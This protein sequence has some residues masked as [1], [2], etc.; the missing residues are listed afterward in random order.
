MGCRLGL[1]TAGR[2][3]AVV[4]TELSPGLWVSSD[5]CSK[6]QEGEM[7]VSGG[8]LRCNLPCFFSCVSLQ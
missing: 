2:G 3:W 5:A 6:S 1:G 8:G 7:S 4:T